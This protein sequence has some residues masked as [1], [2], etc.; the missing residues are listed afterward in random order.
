MG[1]SKAAGDT[2]G[3]ALKAVNDVLHYFG[4]E[5]IPMPGTGTTKEKLAT[6]LDLYAD[7][8]LAK[9]P[10][11]KHPQVDKKDIPDMVAMYLRQLIAKA[12]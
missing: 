2:V 12:D 7:K 1:K 3:K 6:I 4:E 8:F 9:H 10:Q 11:F 5:P